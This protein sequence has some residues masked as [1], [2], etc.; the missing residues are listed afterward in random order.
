[1]GI[2]QPKGEGEG[3]LVGVEQNTTTGKPNKLL[4]V[5]VTDF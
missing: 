3:T 2:T 5:V 1:M 4:V